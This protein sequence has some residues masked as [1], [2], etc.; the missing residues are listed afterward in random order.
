MSLQITVRFTGELRNLASQSSLGLS[1]EEGSTLSDVL[2]TLRDLVCLPFAEQVLEP[3]LEGKPAMGLLML[4]RVLHSGA[5][6][7]RLVFDGD[8]VAFV[9]RMEGG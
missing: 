5:E 4:N 3:L 6:L 8:V 2:H 9:M 1:M 7:D